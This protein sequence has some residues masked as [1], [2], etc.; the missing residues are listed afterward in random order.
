MK[1]STKVCQVI[2]CSL[3]GIRISTAFDM[4]SIGDRVKVSTSNIVVIRGKVVN[5]CLSLTPW[6][7]LDQSRGPKNVNEC[8]PSLTL[9]NRGIWKSEFLRW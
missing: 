5:V 9:L 8:F 6:L 1:L 7:S 3:S 2:V 4:F